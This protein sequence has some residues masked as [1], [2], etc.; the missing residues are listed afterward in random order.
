MAHQG[1]KSQR[2][3]TFC[4]YVREYQLKRLFEPGKK[5]GSRYIINVDDHS[6]TFIGEITISG[7]FRAPFDD[8]KF[9]VKEFLKLK[10]FWYVGAQKSLRWEGTRSDWVLHLKPSISWGS[11]LYKEWCQCQNNVPFYM[12]KGQ[13]SVTIRY[14]DLNEETIAKGKIPEKLILPN[15]HLLRVPC[16]WLTEKGGRFLKGVDKY[17][18]KNSVLGEILVEADLSVVKFTLNYFSIDAQVI[19]ELKIG[20][21]YAVEVLARCGRLLMVSRL[22]SGKLRVCGTVLFRK[23]SFE[24]IWSAIFAAIEVDNVKYLREAI[25]VGKQSHLKI[26]GER[27]ITALGLSVM[28]NRLDLVK[29]LLKACAIVDQKS[30]GGETALCLAL[31]FDASAE[32]IQELINAGA[33]VNGRDLTG[34]SIRDQLRAKKV[35]V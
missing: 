35:F 13:V 6:I 23:D 27:G 15:L 9:W 5:Y 26:Q 30:W 21:N 19:N 20:N 14:I 24:R 28:K 18:G 2:L 4:D 33:N 1:K 17:N 29:E 8:Y 25:A 3:W 7:S 16:Q 31:H 34:N 12:R 22:V 11:D 32:I 10:G